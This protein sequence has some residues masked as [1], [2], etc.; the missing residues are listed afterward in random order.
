MQELV[1]TDQRA[2]FFFWQLFHEYRTHG[3]AWRHLEHIACR[4]MRAKQCLD[5]STQRAIIAADLSQVCFALHLGYF[6]GVAKNGLF[7]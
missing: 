4:I 5:T 1:A 3:R 7:R 6:N 2:S